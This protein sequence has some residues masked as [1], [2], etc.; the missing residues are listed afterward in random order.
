MSRV[1]KILVVGAGVAGPAVCYWLNKFGFSPT[2]IEKNKTIRKG[3]YAM[4]VRGVAVN[5]IKK[6]GIY[7]AICD[8]RTQIEYSHYVDAQGN[9]LHEEYGE[10][11]GYRQGEEVE[12]VRGNLIEILM[13]AI[14]NIP[15][16]FNQAIDRI[17]QQDEK[18]VVK[19]KDGQTENYDLLIGADGLHSAIRRMVFT[20]EEYHLLNLGFY[21]SVFSIPNY[22]NLKHSEMQLEA[23]EKLMHISSDENPNTA[24]AEFML[25]SK[26]E[27]NDIRDEKEQKNF[28]RETFQDTGWEA[29]NLLQLMENSGD[30]YFD[31]ITQVKMN[32]W[33]KGRIALVGDAGYCASPLS[34]Q[35]TSLALVGAYILAGELRAAEENY[36]L[37]F[38]RYNELLHPF[39]EANQSFGSQVSETFL[40]PGE[41]SK[42]IAEQ[43]TEN[44]L[45]KLQT[46][47]NA[48]TLPDY[49]C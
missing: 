9:I 12:I 15:C 28:L 26:H 4:D 31:S 46:V 7:K 47:S 19:F 39:V 25:R 5:I 14:S 21:I 41:I 2:L 16:H 35:G 8:M 49:P 10:K 34:G 1:K 6:I 30:F 48:I 33:T 24:F 42:E 45:E 17:V 18:V 22:L 44:F 38:A 29:N 43:R 36:S 20:R 32:S 3:G 13:Q 27:L 37:A 40:V 23:K 11:I